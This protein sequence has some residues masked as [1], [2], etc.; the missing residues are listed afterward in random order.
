MN[1]ERMQ[2]VRDF[3]AGLEP[4]QVYMEQWCVP[5]SQINSEEACYA[6]SASR[7]VKFDN[8]CNTAA[9]IAGWTVI[10]FKEE[11]SVLLQNNTHL[12]FS[13]LARMILGI[14]WEQA[15]ELFTPDVDNS[16]RLNNQELVVAVLDNMLVHGKP[17]WGA[18]GDKLDIPLEMAFYNDE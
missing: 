9:C 15:S 11:A 18:A 12:G 2:Q 10:C 6:V 5:R 7:A 14:N 4:E 13:D 3:I 16:E 8:Y 17:N 1:K